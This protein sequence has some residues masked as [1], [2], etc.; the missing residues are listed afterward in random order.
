MRWVWLPASLLVV[1]ALTGCGG[2]DRAPKP[3]DRIVKTD[4]HLTVAEYRAI[5]AEYRKLRPLQERSDDSGRLTQGRRAC[6]ELR[7]PR[8]R[9]VAR[10]RDDCNNA[11]VFFLA[12]RKLERAADECTSGSERDRIV[13]GRA[14]YA[15]MADAIRDTTNGGTAINAELNRRAIDG[16]CADSIGMTT[17]QVAQY[18]RAEHAARDAVDAISV[19]DAVGFA[20]AQSELADAL[21]AGASGDPLRGI[22]RACRPPGVKAPKPKATPRKRSTPKPKPKPLPQVPDGGGVKA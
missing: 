10:V 19:A 22:V 16:L 7:K 6:E 11:I 17:Y 1:I 18:R 20:R 13:C 4:G 5:V 14:R 2:D 3:P 8:T 9:L 15:R 21:D 12:L